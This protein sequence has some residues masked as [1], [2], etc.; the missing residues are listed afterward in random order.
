ML[1]V[2]RYGAAD[3][4]EEQLNCQQESDDSQGELTN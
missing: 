4:R 2:W 3:V 1:Y